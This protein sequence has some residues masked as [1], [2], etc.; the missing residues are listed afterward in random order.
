[1]SDLA[2][3][4]A[5]DLRYD[6]GTGPVTATM[7][8]TGGD[9]YETA[10][11]PFAE[12]EVDADTPITLTVVAVDAAGNTSTTSEAGALVLSHCSIG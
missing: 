8:P 10:V 6:T 12:D 3:V 2:G 9:R 1:M 4:A 7:V 11:G 5:V